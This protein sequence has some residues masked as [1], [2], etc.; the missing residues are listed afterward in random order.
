MSDE[1]EPQLEQ[2]RLVYPCAKRW[3]ELDGDAKSR[4]CQACEI[5][6]FNLSGM[7]THEAL[8]V[9]NE[10]RGSLCA[11]VHRRSDGSVL[12]TDRLVEGERAPGAND[13]VTAARRSDGRLVTRLLDFRVPVDGRDWQGDTALI[14]AAREGRLDIA[15]L[16]LDAGAAVNLPDEQH[17]MTPLMWAALRGHTTLAELLLSRGADPD[18]HDRYGKTAAVL[19]Q[20]TPPPRTI[21]RER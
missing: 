5:P 13:L 8:T 20:P 1:G 6:V 15:G 16:L 4:F 12:T 14:A 7:S 2:L 21:G 11:Q 19:T 9:V 17:G 18:L 3:E 10:H